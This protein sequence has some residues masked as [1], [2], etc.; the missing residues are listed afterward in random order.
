MDDARLSALDTAFL[1][2]ESAHAPL[3]LGA[4][5]VCAPP[6]RI[7]PER[8]TALLGDRAE[9]LPW[10]RR[11]AHLSRLPTGAGVWVEDRLFRLRH[12]VHL[13]QLADADQAELSTLASELMA[14]PLDLNRPLW[15]LHVITGLSEG[16]FAVLVK[17]HHALA[18][19]LR[20]VELG[21]GLLDGFADLL[22]ATPT[23]I[24]LA[25]PPA[26]RALP[27]GLAAPGG[28][29]GLAAPG[30]LAGL[31]AAAAGSLFDLVKPGTAV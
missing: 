25:A 6:E 21:V 9:R 28:L 19:G 11:R 13:H 3:H 29:A 12:H 10:L 14:E 4:L 24:E 18:D 26:L 1:C 30:G 2:M 23:T 17:L 27:A 15:Q 5:A 20:A 31:A 16:R 22:A 8:L 7:P